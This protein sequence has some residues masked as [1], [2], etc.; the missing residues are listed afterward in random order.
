MN[1]A[2]AID[3][4]SAESAPSQAPAPADSAAALSSDATI[5]EI[6]SPPVGV[7]RPDATVAET[8]ENLRE[9]TRTA[10]IT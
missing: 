10:F 7:F 6:M 1:K 2:A 3:I 8:I 5:R 9:A 4:G